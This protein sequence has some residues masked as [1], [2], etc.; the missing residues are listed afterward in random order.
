MI[1]GSEGSRRLSK[2]FGWGDVCVNWHVSIDWGHRVEQ[3]LKVAEE[4]RGGE[5]VVYQWPTAEVCWTVTGA[6]NVAQR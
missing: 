5:K 4:Q 2:P 6:D 1:A 3:V